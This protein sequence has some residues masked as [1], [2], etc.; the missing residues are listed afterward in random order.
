M[1]KE[2]LENRFKEAIENGEDELD[3]YLELLESGYGIET[4]REHMGNEAA[5]H[6]KEFC[7]THGLL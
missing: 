5:E 1:N 4:V 3:L 2:E 6:M 7:E